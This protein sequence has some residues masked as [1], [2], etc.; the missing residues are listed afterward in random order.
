MNTTINLTGC[1][2][3]ITNTDKFKSTLVSMKFKNDLTRETATLRSLLSMVLLGG[4][5]QLPS[6]KSLAIHLED[7]YGAN[8]TSNV[9]T[10][11]QAQII[12]LSSTFVNENY[13]VS[14]EALFEQQLNLMKD[15]L[16]DPNFENGIFS[17]NIVEAKKRELKE[18]LTALK[19][20]KY[21]YALDQTLDAMGKNQVLGISGIGYEE[22]IDQIS[23]QD[24][25][26]A[27]KKMLEEDT[28]EIYAIGHFN[29]KHIELLKNT[30]P[31]APSKENFEAA[32]CFKSEHSDVEHLVE[33]QKITQSKFNMGFA[34]NIDFISPN[35]EAMTIFNGIFGAFS[36]SRL[37]KNVREK[38]SLCYYISSNYDA[39]NGIVM[40]S[41]GIEK[42]KAEKVEALV[43]EQLHDIQQGH[44]S[45]EELAITK[46]M[47]ENSLKK[48]QDEQS[49]IVLLAYNRD[50]VQKK[51]TIQEYLDKLMAV[52]KEEI[53]AV[54]QQLSL[55]TTFLLKGEV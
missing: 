2:L 35:H 53:V 27:L 40:V 17:Q 18:R 11:G 1:R 33:A 31:F 7:L 6:I 30:F 36:H 51:E 44:I 41:C 42:D 21:T 55:D 15:I 43:L 47:F 29:D 22:D 32:T 49:N 26:Q 50:I 54:S 24:L 38:H 5:R 12:H 19:D 25:T 45:D 10:K 3:H 16:F 46:M 9:S 20:D 52:T 39:F 37:F 28:I 23:A 14:S 4:T 34:A 48:S 8:I 13:L